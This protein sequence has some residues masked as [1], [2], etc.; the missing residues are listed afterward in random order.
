MM[1]QLVQDISDLLAI[2]VVLLQTSIGIQTLLCSIYYSYNH[3]YNYYYMSTHYFAAV[4]KIN[5][6][7]DTYILY[8][9]CVNFIIICYYW[10]LNHHNK[11]HTSLK[12]QFLCKTL[13]LATLINFQLHACII[14]ILC[15]MCM[16]HVH[17]QLTTPF[18]LAAW[19]L[20]SMRDHC[21]NCF[22]EIDHIKHSEKGPGQLHIFQIWWMEVQNQ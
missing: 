21:G 5:I 20:R 12:V 9:L 6:Q 1:F 22:A 4:Y 18:N 3:Y 7:C 13:Y 15:L 10:Q 2:H 8:I 17:V 19:Q 14:I 11:L 16:T